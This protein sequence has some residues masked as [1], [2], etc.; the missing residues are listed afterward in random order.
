MLESGYDSQIQLTVRSNMRREE[1]STAADLLHLGTWDIL[2][3]QEARGASAMGHQS[4]VRS[5]R[6]LDASRSFADL[7]TQADHIEAYA[8]VQEALHGQEFCLEW[9]TRQQQGRR[10]LAGSAM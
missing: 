6:K 1:C 4:G 8:K 3:P 5:S 9:Y 2:R 10:C 7:R